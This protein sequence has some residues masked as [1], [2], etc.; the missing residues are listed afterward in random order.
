[1]KIFHLL[2]SDFKIS[3]NITSLIDEFADCTIDLH[4]KIWKSQN[5]L[6]TFTKMSAEEDIQIAR[7]VSATEFDERLKKLTRLLEARSQDFIKVTKKAKNINFLVYAR[8]QR[9]NW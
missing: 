7:E 2:A 4:K 3:E 5:H 9:F 6:A 1:M 8:L